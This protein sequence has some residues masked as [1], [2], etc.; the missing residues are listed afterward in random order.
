[1]ET[2]DRIKKIRKDNNISIRELS[3]LSKVARS[4][5]SDIENNKVATSGITLSKL[6]EALGVPIDEFFK[7]ED[8]IDYIDTL[9]DKEAL[10]LY[11]AV[12]KNDVLKRL[13][14]KTKDLDPIK[15][16]KILKMVDIIEED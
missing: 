8:S 7:E 14:T 5:I 16:R 3:E 6:A 12:Q 10:E 9:N 2:G 15:I 13:I 1:M 11:K 4:T